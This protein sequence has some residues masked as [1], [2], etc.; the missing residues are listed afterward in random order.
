MNFSFGL[1]KQLQIIHAIL[2]SINSK[3][4]LS[5]NILSVGREGKEGKE[6]IPVLDGI[7]ER[8][9]VSCEGDCPTH[10]VT[11]TGGQTVGQ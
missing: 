3:W 6:G 5:R 1:F 11:Q 9:I 4:E 10:R 7:F 2:I 8:A